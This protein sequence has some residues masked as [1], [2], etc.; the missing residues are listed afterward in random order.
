MKR[1][2]CVTVFFLAAAALPLFS[3]A[4][5]GPKMLIEGK[6]FDFK[7]IEEGKVITHTFKVSNRGDQTLEIRRVSPG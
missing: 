6:E 4:A 7:E 3:Q 1:F 2:F 5:S